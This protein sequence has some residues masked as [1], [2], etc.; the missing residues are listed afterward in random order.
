MLP[1]VC[2]FI[3]VIPVGTPDKSSSEVKFKVTSAMRSQRGIDYLG[4][5]DKQRGERNR[6]AVFSV[7]RNPFSIR[8][9]KKIGSNENFSRLVCSCHVIG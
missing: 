2:A 9:K 4:K 8:E 7:G 6:A 5:V 1:K 3:S